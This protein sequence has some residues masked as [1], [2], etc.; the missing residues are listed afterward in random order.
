MLADIVGKLLVVS[1]AFV[2]EFD[3]AV[4]DNIELLLFTFD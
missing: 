1:C 2:S 3:R 4:Y